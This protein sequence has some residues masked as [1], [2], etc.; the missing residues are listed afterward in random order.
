MVL[1]GLA[2][3]VPGIGGKVEHIPAVGGPHILAGEQLLDQGL[4]ID[5]LVFFGVVAGFGIGVVPPQGLTAVL[6]DTDGLIG[7]LG[8]ELVE[9]GTVSFDG[10]AV[11]AEIVVVADSVGDGNVGVVGGTGRDSCHGGQAGLVHLVNQCVQ[12][13]MVVDDIGFIDAVGIDLIAEAPDNDGGMVVVLDDQF[14]HLLDGVFLTVGKVGGDVGNFSPE[15]QTLFITQVVEI[16]VVLIVGQSDGGETA[17]HDHVHILCMVLGQQ[18]IAQSQTV[19]MAGHTPQGI[20]FAVEDEAVVGIDDVGTAAEA[21]RN[22][23]AVFQS[24]GGGIQVRILSCLPLVN[25]FDDKTGLGVGGGG[26]GNHCA[27]G[28]GNHIG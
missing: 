27:F 18:S 21:G 28:I 22:G 16:P 5:S 23:V 1:T 8:M 24:D 7:M 10:A 12:L 20:F 17:F 2:A 19:L 6:G 25:V 9:P 15:N 26:L 13:L 4:M 3:L 11:P 14:G